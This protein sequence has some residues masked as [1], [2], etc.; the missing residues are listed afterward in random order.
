VLLHCMLYP[1][2]Q[3]ATELCAAARGAE[4]KGE[5]GESRGERK[6]RRE[7]TAFLREEWPPDFP[8]LKSPK[9]FIPVEQAI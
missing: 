1:L 6:A 7:G 2:P 3:Q 4:V 9:M 5:S 8:C